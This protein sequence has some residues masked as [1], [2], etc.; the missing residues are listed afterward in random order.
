MFRAVAMPAVRKIDCVSGKWRRSLG[1]LKT[2]GASSGSM[3]EGPSAP[4]RWAPY[5]L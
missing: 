4:S 1:A 2:T 5:S 3:L